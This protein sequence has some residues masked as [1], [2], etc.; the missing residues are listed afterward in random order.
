M[1]QTKNKAL[2]PEYREISEN[3][4][5]TKNPVKIGKIFDSTGVFTCFQPGLVH[6]SL[7]NLVVLPK[8]LKRHIF[9]YAYLTFVY[10]L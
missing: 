10:I 4:I 7:G 9:P 3:S 2:S 6:P 5:I 8:Y 1:K